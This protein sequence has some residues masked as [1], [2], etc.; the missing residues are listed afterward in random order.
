[1]IDPKCL[2]GATKYIMPLCIHAIKIMVGNFLFSFISQYMTKIS[3]PLFA[4]LWG[5]RERWQK[6]VLRR[7]QVRL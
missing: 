3:F 5:Q 7:L 1:M 2:S 6:P 4:C